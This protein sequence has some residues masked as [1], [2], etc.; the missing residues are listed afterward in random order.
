YVAALFGTLLFGMTALP[1]NV[2]MTAHE[3]MPLLGQTSTQTLI[4]SKRFGR[5]FEDIRVNHMPH[6]QV[7]CLE[8][9]PTRACEALPEAVHVG[10]DEPMVLLS[11]S[12]TTGKARI[13]QLSEKNVEASVLGYLD[14]MNFEKSGQSDVRYILATPFSTAYGLMILSACLLRSF[15]IIPIGEGFTLDVFYALAEAHRATHYEGGTSVPLLM[16]QTAGRPIPH[17]IHRLKHFGFGGS[18]VSGNM[19]EA[20][21]KA[22]PGIR[23]WQGYGMTEAA[24]LITKYANTQDEK[25]DSVGTA[26]KGVKIAVEVDGSVTDAPYT[27]G[28]IVV[29]GPNVM[30][31]YYQN[32]E[33]TDN[34][35]K[36]GHLYT[37]DLGYLDE[38]GYLYICGRK[39]NVVIVRG[40][41]VHPEEVEACI[42]SSLL[43][44]DCVVYGETD[45][46]GHEVVCAD[47]VPMNK[48][49]QIGEIEAH[50]RTRLAD[51]KQPQKIRV[52]DA[53]PKAASG[54]TGRLARDR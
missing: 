43:V 23:F 17:D 45:A 9:L 6:L 48:Q 52:V 25:L 38:D 30:L 51:Y 24:P 35:L 15:P 50:C 8:D 39:K 32:E 3:I 34:V 29:Q 19:L 18:K 47:V 49:V 41:N 26:I 40:L 4:T 31:G 16:E 12:G 54:K 21:L 20:L 11:T 14:K 7:I 13:V 5:M 28:E 44:Q 46:L 53:I 1:L 10:P 42:L 36:N 27:T 33:E 2:S 37:G 22:Y